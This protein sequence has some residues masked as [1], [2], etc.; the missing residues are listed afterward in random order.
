MRPTQK[1]DSWGGG[2]TSINLKERRG[3][4]PSAFCSLLYEQKEM[5][6]ETVKRGCKRGEEALVGMRAS[7]ISQW[8]GG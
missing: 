5:E 7:M 6:R 1:E 8:V 2:K 4:S 3:S